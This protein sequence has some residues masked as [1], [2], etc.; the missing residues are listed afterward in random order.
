V[1]LE[2]EIRLVVNAL[3][4][5]GGGSP[6]LTRDRLIAA[7]AEQ[8][9][10]TPAEIAAEI[11][12]TAEAG[13]DPDAPGRRLCSKCGAVP[14]RSPQASVCTPCARLGSRAPA[15]PGALRAAAL[16]DRAN[17]PTGCRP[18]PD[19]STRRRRGRPPGPPSAEPMNQ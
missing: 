8:T 7:V 10:A 11:D 6:P 15:D 1:T 2:T 18:R 17:G 13:Q 16:F 14:P 3:S 19:L 9:G 5:S 12:R 4:Q